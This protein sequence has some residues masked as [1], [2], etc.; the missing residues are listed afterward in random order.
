MLKILMGLQYTGY[1][2][3][4]NPSFPTNFQNFLVNVLVH[5]E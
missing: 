4:C 5:P 1:L 3:K 2:A